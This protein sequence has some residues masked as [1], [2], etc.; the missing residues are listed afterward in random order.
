MA[1]VE[2]VRSYTFEAAHSLPRVPKEHKCHNMHG[3]SFRVD[4][5]LSGEIDEEMG[6]F[7]DYGE[8]DELWEPLHKMLDHHCLN[9]IDGLENPTSENLARWLWGKL[10]PQLD[11]L[12]AVVVYEMPDAYCVYRG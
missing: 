12:D 3:H 1:N 9:E 6:W 5:R 2:L 10:K 4:L 7:I 11:I 8:V